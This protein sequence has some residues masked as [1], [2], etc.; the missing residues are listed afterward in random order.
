MPDLR[1]PEAVVR[2]NLSAG[3]D[4]GR[5]W[6]AALPE[7]VEQMCRRWKLSLGPAFEGGCVGFVAPVEREGGERDVLKVSPVDEETRTE[8]DALLFWDGDG[9]ARLLD[10]DARLGALL[11]ERLE[12]GTSLED[13]PDRDE[14]ITIACRLLKSLW[15]PVPAG[16]P[17][18]LV[19]DLALRWSREIPDRYRRLGRP[20]EGAL[21]E[22][23]ADLCAELATHT[24][25]L[26]LANRDYHL[27]NVLAATREP[28]LLIDPKPLAGEAAF[29]TGHLLRSLLPR[30]FDDALVGGLVHRLASELDLE[31]E[32]IRSWALV[33]S[34]EDAL[35][36]MSVGGTDVGRDLECARHLANLQ[37]VRPDQFPEEPFSSRSGRV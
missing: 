27:G 11:L 12:P 2:M 5:A 30:G 7:I 29:D 25:D 15:R 37:H 31:V 24:E 4:V 6:L 35:W 8:A 33:R 18:P 13:H 17:F 9:T 14:A 28:W 34:V 20:F 26:V 3:W 21:A 23:A 16:H 1:V 36:G 22:Q 32:A 19:P 10:S